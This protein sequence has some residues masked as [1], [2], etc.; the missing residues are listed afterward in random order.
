MRDINMMMVIC[1]SKVEM[2]D[3]PTD[4]TVTLQNMKYRVEWKSFVTRGNTLNNE[5]PVIFVP[6]CMWKTFNLC[7]RNVLF[8]DMNDSFV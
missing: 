8:S 7:Y 4:I 3:I 5:Y 2:R 1:E 6:L